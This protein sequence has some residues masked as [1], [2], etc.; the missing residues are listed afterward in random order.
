MENCIL[1]I[2][3]S[4][5]EG[6]VVLGVCYVLETVRGTSATQQSCRQITGPKKNILKS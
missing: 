2:K 5:K 6:K 3:L 4:K 1:S